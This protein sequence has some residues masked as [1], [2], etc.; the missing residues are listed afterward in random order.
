MAYDMYGRWVPDNQ[1]DPRTGY[2]YG[3][4]TQPQ[5]GPV[6]GYSSFNQPTPPMQPQPAPQPPAGITMTPAMMHADIIQITGEQDVR[7]AIVPADGVPRMYMTD[8]E[9]LFATKRMGPNGP[10][11]TFYDPRPEEP[12]APK[13]DPREFVKYTDL[14]P[15]IGQ[16]V[17][18]KFAQMTHQAAIEDQQA[19]PAAHSVPRTGARKDG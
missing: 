13:F 17:D 5:P 7:D 2:P 10:K 1:I 18:N 16:Y 11:I 9:R 4:R 6:P 15:I 3:M 14:G 12:P 8:D 19:A